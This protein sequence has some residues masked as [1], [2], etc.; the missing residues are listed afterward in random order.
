M[1]GPE[2]TGDIA[3]TCRSLFRMGIF[4]EVTAQ[5]LTRIVSRSR[6]AGKRQADDLFLWDLN[7]AVF[8]VG[9][10]RYLGHRVLSIF[11]L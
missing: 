7:D 9:R 2:A 11:A 8:V 3:L 5:A 6:C 1:P 10:K 4:S